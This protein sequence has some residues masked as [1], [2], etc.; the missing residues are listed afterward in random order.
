MAMKLTRDRRKEL[1][2]APENR[3]VSPPWYEGG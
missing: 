1:D 3:I 2:D